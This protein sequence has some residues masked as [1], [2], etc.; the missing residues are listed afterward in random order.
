MLGEL[1]RLYRAVNKLGVR[2]MAKQIGV[3]AAT[4]SRIERGLP[5]DLN[6]WLAVQ[7]WLL[8]RRPAAQRRT[9]SSD[10]GRTAIAAVRAAS[11]HFSPGLGSHST[12]GRTPAG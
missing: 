3:S 9:P 10:R 6:T 2:A 1:L 4:I 11:R 8:R 7:T 12:S 5:M